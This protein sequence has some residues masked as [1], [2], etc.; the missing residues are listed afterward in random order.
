MT[1]KTKVGLVQIGEMFGDQYYLPY[2]IG[3]LQAYAQKHLK[4]PEKFDF[5]LPI[6]KN[7]KIAAAVEYLSDAEI[8]FFSVYVWNFQISLE[9][10]KCIKQKNKSAVIVFGGPQ[11]PE[12]AAGME[13]FLVKNPFIDIASYGEG[14]MPFTSILENLNG[15]S[16]NNVPAIG[17]RDKD[18][19]FLFNSP[20]E[21]IENFEVSPSVYLEGIFDKLIKTNP[22]QKWSALIE[23]NRGCPFSCSYCYWGKKTRNRL[24]KYKIEKV[25]DEIDWFSRNKIEFVFC[26]DANFGILKRDVAIV[27]KAAENKKKYGFPKAFSIQ[28]TKNS[29]EKI[30]MLQKILDDYGLQK[31]VNL[32]LQTLNESTLRFI[33]RSN[34]SMQ[35]Y[36]DLQ[37]MFS[38]NKILTFSDMILA[39]PGESYDT[40]TKGVSEVI[41]SGQ[42]NRIQ[43]INLV[44]LENT[45]MANAE[46]QKKYGI[47]TSKSRMISHHTSLDDIAEVSEVQNLVVET[48]T[49]P[50]KDWLKT[51]V[52]CWMTSLLYFN[53]LLQIPLMMI[54]EKSSLRIKELI[55][56]FISHSNQYD[57]ISKI[58]TFF[59]NKA[60]DIQVGDCEYVAS[61]EWLNVWWPADELIF[62]KLCHERKLETFY[63]EAAMA[64]TDFL[65]KHTIEFPNELLHDSIKLNKNLIKVPF[66]ESDLNISLNYNIYDKF[67]GLL[68]GIDIPLERG[69][70]N[71]IIDRTS[72]K[73]NSWND[74]SREVV[75]YGSKKGAYLYDCNAMNRDR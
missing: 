60:A 20:S 61:K 45:E 70:F 65:L 11:V 40:F 73:W 58:V 34:I 8:V 54:V 39:L 38:Q 48:N 71:S 29:T 42:H 55:E 10:A 41:E 19:N 57:E 32:A 66:V 26:C 52:F 46:Y 59:T 6:Y 13:I 56:Y 75:W 74:W 2:S 4:R 31:G 63:K 43:F 3:L 53:K 22:E 9:L 51:R 25:F 17:F 12:S 64:I 18:S 14:E 28:N 5:L 50:K 23:T 16:W 37:H 67:Q 21:K 44:V 15:L 1:K 47:Q 68:N 69:H 24:H 7:V 72:E 62:I 35:T 49:M 36:K 33:N 27:K 30:F